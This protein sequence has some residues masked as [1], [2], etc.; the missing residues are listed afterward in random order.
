[1]RCTLRG[2]QG[3][4]SENGFDANRGGDGIRAEDARIAVHDSE[5][6]GGRGGDGDFFFDDI[7]GDGGHGGRIVDSLFFGSGS[8]LLGGNG[9]TEAFECASGGH[10]LHL[11]GSATDGYLL[12]LSLQGG[13]ASCSRAPNGQPLATSGGATATIPIP[14]LPPGVEASKLHLQSCF[15]DPTGRFVLG[16]P[17]TIVALDSSF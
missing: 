11:I 7:P 14:S 2:G 6:R 13:S 8:S 9:G 12:E 15:K 4:Y 5:V 10:G 16:S 3:A 1:M 17:S